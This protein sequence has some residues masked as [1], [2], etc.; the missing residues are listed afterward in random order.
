MSSDSYKVTIQSINI[1]ST[2]NQILFTLASGAGTNIRLYSLQLDP[3]DPKSYNLAELTPDTPIALDSA[4]EHTI[5]RHVHERIFR[6]AAVTELFF[7]SIL[8]HSDLA[9]PSNP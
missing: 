6:E 3:E 8:D 2:G 1:T 5:T 7:T 4:L 9:I